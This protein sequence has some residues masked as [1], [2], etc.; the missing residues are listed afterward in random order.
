MKNSGSVN[1]RCRAGLILGSVL[2]L[3]PTVLSADISTTWRHEWAQGTPLS[4]DQTQKFESV[5]EPEW[6][7]T[8]ADVDWTARLRL[9]FNSEIDTG[10]YAK[11]AANYS[12]INGAVLDSEHAELSLREFYID[13]EV[14][15][16]ASL[17]D[18][19]WRLGKQQ[20]V[21]G[22]ADGLK[23]LD[24]VNPQSYR[25]FILDSFEDSR[26]PLW[27]LNLT[28][29][30]GDSSTL[31]L[32]WIPDTTY[33]E[34]AQKGSVYEVHAP[35]RIPDVRPAPGQSVTLVE[36]NKPSRAFKDSDVGVRYKLF[37]EGWDMTLNYLYHTLDTPVFYQVQTAGSIQIRSEY[38]RSHLVGA[39]FSNVFG[40]FIL[41]AEVGYQTDTY[42]YANTASSRR[43]VNHHQEL[44]SVIGIDWQGLTD[45]LISVQWFRSQL[46]SYDTS[47]IREQTDQTLSFLF[48]QHIDN[49]TWKTEM[50]ALHSLNHDDGLLRPKVSYLWLSN[51]EVWLGA[52]V[53]YGERRG[54]YGQFDRNDR[55]V[56][57]FEWGF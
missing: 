25:E 50:L 48:R 17:P 4:Q 46:F 56:A 39:S 9:R 38:E 34:L 32:L 8:V 2:A 43:G 23:V 29:I 40:D 5:I 22:Q 10:S 19:E 49:Q 15:E 28:V 54:L 52:D 26:I 27:M 36:I 30:T 14:Y 37:W 11:R 12:S 47:T 21:W 57:G 1:R 42:H 41:R 18:M 3:L 6:Q 51:L 13:G 31:Q 16:H 24:Q 33:H 55:L 44:A 7:E 45:T 20:V 35:E 53:F